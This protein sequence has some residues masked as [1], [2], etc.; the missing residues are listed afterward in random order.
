MTEPWREALRGLDEVGPDAAVYRR[1]GEGPSR[2][3]PPEGPS[4]GKRII[5]GVTAVAV[6]ALAAGFAWRAFRPTSTSNAVSP[7]PSPGSV[8][9]LGEDGSVLWPENTKAGLQ[10]TQAQADAGDAT[11]AWR[12]DPSQV[13]TKFAA[14]VL[15]WDESSYSMTETSTALIPG[16]G[17]ITGKKL[18]LSRLVAPCPTPVDGHALGAMCYGGTEDVVLAQPVS[19]GGGGIW[20]VLSVSA[21]DASID[22]PTGQVVRSG[23]S[24]DAHISVPDGLNG[25][26]GFKSCGGASGVG[27]V[28]SGDQSIEV[29]AATGC[30]QSSAGFVWVASSPDRFVDASLYDPMNSDAAFVSFTA[31]PIVVSIPENVPTATPAASTM[32]RYTD[33]S[34][35]RV[36]YPS[37]WTA[38]PIDVQEKVSTRGVVIANGPN[39]LASPNSATPG[40]IGPDLGSAASDLVALS[41]ITT[42][43]GPPIGLPPGD[44]TPLPLSASDLKVMP[45]ICTTCPASMRFR[46]NGVGYEI[47]LWAGPDASAADVVAAKSII[48]SFRGASLHPGAVTEGWTALSKPAGGFP[49][50]VGTPIALSGRPE[51]QVL[52]VMFVMRPASGLPM[53]ALDLVPDTCG[54]GQDQRWDPA[55]SADPHDMSRRDGHR[56]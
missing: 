35:W 24:I 50:G 28:S 11:V 7:P 9:P 25:S 55:G 48:E 5:A 42:S 14:Q 54:E 56:L 10:A 32:S 53:Y 36:A 31:V 12:L 18:E 37:A 26:A 33:P 19:R 34:G 51:L 6:F 8:V 30:G 39:G 2:D 46:S 40:P 29:D 4:R 52:G 44:D 27:G 16:N 3:E 15:G 21:P 38:S 49:V 1:A 41:I 22:A 20:S 23:D 13:A 47:D 17:N 45:G 43:G